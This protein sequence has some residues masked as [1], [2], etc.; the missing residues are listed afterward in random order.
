MYELYF[1]EKLRLQNLTI[2][3]F[4]AASTSLIAFLIDSLYF[5]RLTCLNILD[6]H[7][8]I[9]VGLAIFLPTAVWNTCLAP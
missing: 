6:A 5:C 2:L 3:T 8:N 4:P 9:A 7:I 1:R